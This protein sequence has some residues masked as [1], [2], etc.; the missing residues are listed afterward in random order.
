[1]PDPIDAIMPILQRIQSELAEVRKDVQRVD[2]KVDAVSTDVKDISERM[3]AFEDYFTYTMGLT[4][5]NKSDIARLSKELKA[6]KPAPSLS[7]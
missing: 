7:P 5:Q 4:Q 3:D 2:R 6:L 1:M